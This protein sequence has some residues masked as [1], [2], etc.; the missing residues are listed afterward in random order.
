MTKKILFFSNISKINPKYIF[1]PHWSY[2]INKDIYENFECIIFHM[3]D[4]PYGRGGTPL[5]NL[6]VRGHKTTKLTAF[7]CEKGCD[8]G[9]I[10][11]KKDLTLDG[12]A[13]DIYN[14]ASYLMEDMI[15]DIV[16]NNI[17]PT[18]QSG[19]VVNFSRLCPEDSVISNKS[20]LKEL[21][22]QIRMLDAGG[23]PLAHIEVQNF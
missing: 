21:Y 14:R 15:Y 5:Q 9:P 19:N 11:I 4:L 13:Q 6:I 20:T 8:T 12:R 17:K 1:V 18:E 10:Y 2:L 22:D 7:Q 3:T 23:Y 16:F